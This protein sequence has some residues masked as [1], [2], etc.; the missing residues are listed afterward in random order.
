MSNTYEIR[1]ELE[2]LEN[3]Y[4]NLVW[5]GENSEWGLDHPGKHEFANQIAELYPDEADSLQ[6]CECGEWNDG[7]NNV[8]LAAIR[9][10]HDSYK[11]DIENAYELFPHTTAK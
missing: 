1:D 10:I 6:C 8:M 4:R 3:K 5:L 7:F 11:Y 2:V 9:F